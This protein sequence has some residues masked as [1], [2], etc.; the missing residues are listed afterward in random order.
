[1]S[2]KKELYRLNYSLNYVPPL[3]FISAGANTR[4]ETGPGHEW[5]AGAERELGTFNAI[6]FILEA[7]CKARWLQRNGG[8]WENFRLQSH[9]NRYD[10]VCDCLNHLTSFCLGPPTSLSGQEVEV[11]KKQMLTQAYLSQYVRNK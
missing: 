2:R 3:G 1:M 4:K 7:G 8:N 10:S 5:G 11:K 9:L 6:H